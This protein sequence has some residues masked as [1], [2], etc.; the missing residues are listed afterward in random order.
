M[1]L[2]AGI[3]AS[4]IRTYATAFLTDLFWAEGAFRSRGNPHFYINQDETERFI[5]QEGRVHPWSFAALP[6]TKSPLLMLSRDRVHL[7]TFLE[8]AAVE[9]YHRPPRMARVLLYL[10]LC[11]VQGEI[12][13]LSEAKVEDFLDFWKGP[14][15]PVVDAAIHYLVE[16]GVHL[17]AR[18]PLVY[19]NRAHLVGYFPRR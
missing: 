8:E 16:G 7:L 17:P 1:A 18:R 11:V 15:F 14:L 13:L 19:V 10:P 9:S 4:P 2:S 12:P 5:L 6:A 3:N